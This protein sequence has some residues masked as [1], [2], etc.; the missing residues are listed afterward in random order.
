MGRVELL[1][2]N[3]TYALIRYPSGKEDTIS[4]HDLS[5]YPRER[6]P[7]Q[8]DESTTRECATESSNEPEETEMTNNTRDVEE[9]NQE[10][11]PTVR[12]STRERSTPKRFY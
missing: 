10:N 9:E 12:R 3:P 11:H 1:H 8:L 6:C 7:E 5:P 2:A 4:I